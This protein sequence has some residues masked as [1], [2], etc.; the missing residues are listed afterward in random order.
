MKRI[1][2]L[3]LLLAEVYAQADTVRSRN[4]WYITPYGDFHILFV[5]C[6]LEF[7]AGY[8]KLDPHGKDGLWGW[9]P[10]QL[11]DWKEDLADP[12]YNPQKQHGQL[13]QYFHEASFGQFRVTGDYFPYLVR[14]KLS[15]VKNPQGKV[16][17][18]EAFGSG[19]YRKTFLLALNAFGKLETAH[20]TEDRLDQRT[21]PGSGLLN[22]QVS[23]GKYDLVV[24]IYRNIHVNN[25]CD[26]CGFTSPGSLGNIFG[27]ESDTY[28]VFHMGG[29]M[30]DVVLRHEFSHLIYGGNN[31]HTA[32]PG[33]GTHSFIPLIGGF[34]NMSGADRW[35]LVYNAWDRDRLGWKAPGSPFQQTCLDFNSGKLLDG[36]LSYTPGKTWDIWLRDFVT[37][38]DAIRIP[39]PYL[40][41]TV[42]PQYLW[43]ENHQVLD[44]RIDHFKKE[45]A[46]LNA[47]VQ[48]GKYV[49]QGPETF[50]GNNGY[51][52][53][54][55]ANGN[56]DFRI[57]PGPTIL[58][59][60]DWENPLTGLHFL[61]QPPID[62]NQDGVISDSRSERIF[63]KDVRVNGSELPD[64]Y[65]FYEHYPYYGYREIQ[66]TENRFNRI[67]LADNPTPFPVLSYTFPST[68]QD[69]KDNRW[70]YTNGICI[71]VLSKR[72][73]GALHLRIHFDQHTLD[74]SRR[75]CG[76]I[77][78][79]ESLSIGSWQTLTLDQGY[80]VQEVK[81]VQV[82][83][84]DTLFALPTL[85]EV[86]PGNALTL[87]AFSTIRIR[88]GST[89]LIRSG[90]SLVVGKRSR[91][92]VEPGAHLYL[93]NGVK[94]GG[95]FKKIFSL[96]VGYKPSVNPLTGVKDLRDAT[97]PP[98][99]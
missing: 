85:L 56:Y 7:D 91:I 12:V 55:C 99:R 52:W 15:D 24:L 46:G 25:L 94:F 28:A 75:W 9:K 86:T 5:F 33:A 21:F 87:N 45:A 79:M 13:T 61:S 4:G 69:G 64:G 23:N 31:F 3:I 20:Q 68:M 51:I 29:G 19:Y 57:D 97:L 72:E 95:K 65:F 36:S 62:G 77:K 93:E 39:I 73:D 8:E 32:G 90:A 71:E 67:S 30:P 11:P 34:S 6:E 58:V 92:I 63:P 84:G 48:V 16:V 22:K 53:P 66:F 1:L 59:E 35:S 88:N 54:L 2:I 14:H 76:R 27:K 81:K 18:N 96:P 50:S 83:D 78:V 26:N 60:D 49:K 89:L 43:L 37:T 98:L 38:S 70:I 10:G 74:R 40:P 82:L 17:E 42:E 47:Y 80:S 41:S 44:G